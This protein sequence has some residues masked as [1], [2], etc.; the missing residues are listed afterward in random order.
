MG[1]P[2]RPEKS[3]KVHF[4]RSFN[5]VKFGDG[6]DVKGI[7]SVVISRQAAGPR[8]Y[9]SMFA[10]RLRNSNTGDVHWLH[11]DLTMYQANVVCSPCI[12]DGF[13]ESIRCY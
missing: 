4:N 3:I 12:S 2:E 5:V 8:P 9:E 13:Q 7:I 6:T 1:S 10:I 11:Q